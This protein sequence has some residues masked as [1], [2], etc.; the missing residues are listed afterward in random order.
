[1]R[2][3]N[4][5]DPRPVST[6]DRILRGAAVVA[7]ARGLR[8]ATVQDI[9]AASAV[10][11]RTFYQHYP[12]T[13]GVVCDLYIETTT[14][15]LERVRDAVALQDEPQQRLRAAM[16]AYVDFQQ[17]GGRLLMRLQGEAMRPDSMLAPIREEVH[18]A[19][20]AV[21]SDEV[22]S[23]QGARPSPLLLRSLLMGAEG[24][25]MH[26]QRDGEIPPQAVA[27]ARAVVGAMV[28]DALG[29]A[30]DW[31]RSVAGSTA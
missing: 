15:L 2:S 1:M 31:R 4:D 29:A 30:G 5:A 9:L 25:L 28:L 11:R 8:G 16:D 21:L 6:R 7:A 12:N 19:L 20:V 26:L 13:E 3:T 18:D 17:A 27:E 22:Q 23:M 14:A 24:L 10:S